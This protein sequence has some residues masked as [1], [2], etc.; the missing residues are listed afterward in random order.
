MVQKLSSSFTYT[1]IFF[2]FVGKKSLILI[3]KHR[4]VLALEIKK[5]HFKGCK[6]MEE[7]A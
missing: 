4:K 6:V 1:L 5:Y 2:N 3:P 7:H